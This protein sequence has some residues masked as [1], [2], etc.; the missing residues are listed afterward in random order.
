M[1][2]IKSKRRVIGATREDGPFCGAKR[3]SDVGAGKTCRNPAGY[4]TDH[5]GQGRCKFHGGMSPRKHGRYSKVL[6]KSV[7]EAMNE[8]EALETNVMDLEPE[9]KLLRALIVD[10]I[11]RYE[12][13]TDALL[14]WFADKE[15]GTKPR[16]ILD[17]ADA[18]RMIEQVSKIVER[19]HKIKS[20][21]AITLETFR[22]VTEQMGIIVAKHVNNRQILS[23]IEIE[24][25]NLVL[26]AKSF[27]HSKPEDV[28]VSEEE[29]E[30]EDVEE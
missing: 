10:Y 3:H 14:A 8:L 19:I 27:D 20:E 11:N 21:G 16:R 5:P 24:W 30:D 18:S 29:G 12:D 9:L 6:H 7:V 26:D 4:K 1:A 13:I 23:A 17:I 15:S 2:K 25:N 28:S 22:R